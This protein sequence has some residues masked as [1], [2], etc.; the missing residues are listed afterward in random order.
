VKGDLRAKLEV[1]KIS[2]GQNQL[3]GKNIRMLVDAKMIQLEKYRL[4]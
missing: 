4:R 3:K 1:R 2:N